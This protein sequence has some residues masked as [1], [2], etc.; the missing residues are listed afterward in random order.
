MKHQ[1]RTRRNHAYQYQ[2]DFVN[3][4]PT[5]KQRF[6]NEFERDLFAMRQVLNI[7]QK[8]TIRWFGEVGRQY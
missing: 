8:G 6:H 5:R 7:M 3:H 2:R 4:Q 1:N